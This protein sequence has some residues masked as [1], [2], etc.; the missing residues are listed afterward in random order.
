MSSMLA[1][2]YAHMLTRTDII[3]L[4][5]RLE[6]IVGNRSQAARI[7]GLE[8][9]TI[10]GWDTTREIRSRTRERILAVLLENLTEETLEFLTRRSVESSTDVLQTHLSS[11]YERAMSEST[12]N[13]EFTRLVT[14]FDQERQRYEGLLASSNLQTEISTMLQHTLAR[15]KEISLAFRPSPNDIV[16]LTE[17]SRLIPDIVKAVATLSP[18][19]SDNEIARIFN[20]PAGFVNTLSAA[21][22]DSFIAIRAIEPARMTQAFP[23]DQAPTMATLTARGVER[24]AVWHEQTLPGLTPRLAGAT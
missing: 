10:Y 24:E 9:R 17:F 16:R 1:E 19:V 15:A 14:K 4:F 5:R 21:L 20:L 18:Y 8:R 6:E 11:I 12:N 7:C 23:G 2:K 3:H 13:Q 22:H